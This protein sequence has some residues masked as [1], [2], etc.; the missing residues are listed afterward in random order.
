MHEKRVVSVTSKIQTYPLLCLLWCINHLYFKNDIYQSISNKGIILF[1]K[2]V[3][4]GR[5]EN[6]ETSE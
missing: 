6:Y 3:S 2:N 1:Q 4:K 5:S